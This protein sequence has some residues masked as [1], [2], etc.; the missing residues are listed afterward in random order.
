LAARFPDLPAAIVLLDA[1]FSPPPE[2]WA[3]FRHLLDG[4]RSPAYREVLCQTSDQLIFLPTDDQQRKARLVE[5]MGSLPQ[6]VIVSTWENFL[7]HDTEAA[8]AACQAPVLHIGSV[9]PANLARLR[10]LCPQLVTGQTV[11]AGHFHQLET[12]EQVNAMIDRFLTVT[13][14]GRDR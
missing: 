14:N 7:A 6:Q 11:G 1:P 4:L 5:A 2:V 8:A 12:A 9:F 10:E 3:G 13:L